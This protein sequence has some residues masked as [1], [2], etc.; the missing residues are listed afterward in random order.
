MVFVPK[1]D[2]QRWW[3]ISIWVACLVINLA[4]IMYLDF[5][6]FQTIDIPPDGWREPI[7][8]VYRDLL[9]MYAPPLTTMLAIGFARKPKTS[10]LKSSSVPFVIAICSSVAWNGIV[11]IQNV[12]M[13]VFN[14][15]DIQSFSSFLPLLPGGLSFLVTPFLAF[16]FSSEH[17]DS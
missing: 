15:L 14:R 9:A 17:H 8:K 13:S 2:I 4:L 12:R 7:D 5:S 3:I 10:S 1:L 11:M 16:Y 6:Q